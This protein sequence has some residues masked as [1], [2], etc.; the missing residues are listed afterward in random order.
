MKLLYRQYGR[1][2]TREK[3]WVFRTLEFIMSP[4]FEWDVF[5]DEENKMADLFVLFLIIFVDVVAKLKDM[6]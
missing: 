4:V 5:V 6:E 3:F 2:F 1:Q